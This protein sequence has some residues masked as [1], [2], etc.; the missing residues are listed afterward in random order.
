MAVVEKSYKQTE[1]GLIPTDWVVF[2]FG[3]IV[4]YTKGYAFKSNDYK[5]NGIRII[6]VSDTTYD[7]VKKENGIYLEEKFAKQFNNWKLDEGDLIFSTVGSKPPMYDSMVGKVIMV[8]KEFEGCLLNQNAVLIRSKKRKKEIQA[9]L[10]SHFRT[11]RYLQY[12]E[13]IFRG[14]ANQASITLKD[15]FEF[16]IPLPKSDSEQTAIATALSNIDSLISNLEK[17]IEKKRMIKQGVMQELLKPT[18]DWVTYDLYESCELITKGTTPTSI[19]QEFKNGG[20]NFIKIESLTSKG[21]IV[22]DK[23]AYIDNLTHKIL[24]RSQLKVGDL[25]FSIAGALG[26]VALVNE[27]ILPANTNQAL[28]I[29]RLKDDSKI[30][31]DF[32]FYYLNSRK[33]QNHIL[34]ISVQGAQANL[35]LQNISDFKINCPK[36]KEEQFNIAKTLRSLDDELTLLENQQSKYNQ[37]KQGMMQSLLTGKIRLI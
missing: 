28:A 1:V 19:G 14:N 4:D 12:I 32:L 3:E 27:S 5:D 15:L 31:G 24:N 22:P 33:I 9:L 30:N 21:E 13:L 11:K 35:S 20:I 37:I 10:L 2:S 36:I 17:L 6:R 7:S 25:L 23:V 8:S 16:K 34:G 18:V 26:R 29:I